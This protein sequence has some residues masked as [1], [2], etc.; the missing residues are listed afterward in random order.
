[1]ADDIFGN[2]APKCWE[3]NLPVIPV[4]GKAPIPIG[5]TG[6]LGGTPSEPKRVEWIEKYRSKNIGL[7][8]GMELTAGEVLVALDIDD[9]WLLKPILHFFGLTRAQRRAVLSGKRGKKG[10]TIFVR[11]PKSLKSTI[12]KGAGGLGNIDFLAAGKMTVM[13]PSIHPDT[14]KPY[15]VF[16]QPLLEVDFAELPEIT[17]RHIKLM[18][19]AIG[20]EHT[21]VLISGK[22]T[23]DAG[24]ALVAVLVHAGATD[25]EITSIFEALLPD[26]YA[27]NSLKE[28]PEWIRSAREKGFDEAQGETNSLTKALITIAMGSGMVLFNDGDGNAYA[29][30]PHLGKSIA[31]RLGS[32]AFGMWLRHLAHTV[33]EK[34]V[35]SGPLKEA[36]ATLE[37]FALFDGSTIPVYVRIAG[38]DQRVVIDTGQKNGSVVNIDR[39]GWKV[40]VE[41]AYRFVRGAGFGTLPL[42]QNGGA[43]AALQAFL[44]LDEQNYRLLIAFLVNALKPAGPY[45]V[46]LVEGEQG[47]GKSF[48]CEVVKRIVDPN[49]AMRLRLPDKPQDLMIQAKE[50]RLLSFDNAS[51]MSAEMSDALCSLA[52]GGG[53]AVRKLYSDGELYVM[54]YSRPFVINGIG[55]YANRPD[56]MERAIPI[57]LAPMPEGGRKTEAEL[58]AEFDQMLPGVL[59]ALYEAAAH[60]LRTFDETEPPRHLRMADA[61]RWIKAAEGG[62]GEQPGAVI[63]AI[64]V[65]QNEFVVDRVND[66]PLV[67]AL[68]RIVGPLPFEDYI[69]ELFVKII[70]QHDARHHRGLPKSPSALSAQLKRLRP[71]MAKA[72]IKVEFL[73]RGNK[74]SRVRIW[75]EEPGM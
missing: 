12:I 8:L 10:A 24:V 55:G 26:D 34:P 70:E 23:H 58:M 43:L 31:V 52:T 68:R 67:V 29:T 64:A 41:V 48:F 75:F 42:P 51:G 13:P 5:W 46:L 37:A 17:E 72:G 22:A 20:S 18:K 38:D 40:G 54:S 30:L 16:G 19:A 35:S 56:L 65:A 60:A 59:G 61:A 62:M 66:D 3:R 6:V 44:G 27:G 7:L 69:G 21:I 39:D 25:E 50:Y 11:A 71:A 2:E 9:D 32:S 33:L 57:R 45:F 53:L 4:E 73:G 74:G 63:D 15:E 36:V 1:M 28:L 14:G 49:Q 47:S